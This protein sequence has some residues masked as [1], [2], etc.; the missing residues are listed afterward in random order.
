MKLFKFNMLALMLITSIGIYGQKKQIYSRVFDV[1]PQTTAILNLDDSAIV[2]EQSKDNKV[3]L[4]YNIEFDGFSE[5]EVDSLIDRVKLDVTM[6]NNNITLKVNNIMKSHEYFSYHGTGSLFMDNL[7]RSKR[8]IKKDS[9]VRKLKDSI[10]R[11]IR[12]K[13]NEKPIDSIGSW[14]KIKEENGSIRSLKELGGVKIIKGR[15]VIK[16]PHFVK[17]T[18]H[19]NNSYITFVGEISNELSVNLKRGKLSAQQLTNTNNQLKIE[20]AGFEVEALKNGNYTLNNVRKGL[21]GSINNTKISSEF[22]K[23]EIGEI[24][25][26][27]TIVDFKSEYWFYNWTADFKRFDLFSEYSKIHYFYPKSD[28][29]LKVVGNNTV[30]YI[31]ET[32]ITMQ[33]V[34]NGEKFNMMERKPRGQGVFAGAMNFDI[35]HGVIYSYDDPVIFINKEN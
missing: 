10:L 7:L 5:K 1:N 13:N 15:F 25:L 19:A 12:V 31:G 35:V 2:I 3:H 4:N 21:I 20:D 9:I 33:P 24:Q 27:S 26:N 30:N 17:L 18:V 29:S 14:F 8:T 6:F 23:I 28:Y 16:V 11:E 34:R 22:S 32:K